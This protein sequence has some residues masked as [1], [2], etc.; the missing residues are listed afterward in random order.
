MS[1]VPRRLVVVGG[2]S[3]AW[4]AAHAL[5]RSFRH[6]DA[7]VTVLDTGPDAATPRAHWTLPSQRGAHAQLGLGE[8]DFMRAT[9]ATFRLASEHAGWQGGDR[10][11]LHAHGEI[12]VPI[13]AVPFYKGI[14]Q[15][16]LDGKPERADGWSIA[17]LAARQG[18]FAQPMAGAEQDLT[19]SFTYGFH[20]DER[21]R[22][23]PP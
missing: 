19:A 9:G 8:G 11:F 10:R 6:L 22:D 20:V 17:A 21:G 18:R 12:G 16:T 14:L 4:I 2:D 5:R 23:R 7:D 13:G 1:A 3:P 15:R